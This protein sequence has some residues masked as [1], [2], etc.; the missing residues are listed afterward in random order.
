MGKVHGFCDQRFR[1]LF[2]LFQRQLDSGAND[3]AALAVTFQ[4]E[5]VVDLWCGYRDLAGT[6]PWERE[7]LCFVF[8]TSKALL[9]VA[10]LMMVDRGLLDLVTDTAKKLKMPLQF[11]TV[12]RGGTDAGK[13]HVTGQG[14]PSISMG[15]AARYI[16]SHVSIID[17]RDF[18]ATVKL[19]V[20]V[21]KRLDRKTVDAL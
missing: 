16:H 14:V 15:V 1:P 7:T 10:V 19:L 21:V 4:G 2:D 20:A 8:S 11:E 9:N 17:R 6:L 18:E 12:E 13:I 5:Y 3:G